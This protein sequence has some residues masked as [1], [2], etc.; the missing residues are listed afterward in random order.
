MDMDG[1]GTTLHQLLVVG[2]ADLKGLQQ[3]PFPRVGNQ[4]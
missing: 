2:I 3:L 1:S 4:E